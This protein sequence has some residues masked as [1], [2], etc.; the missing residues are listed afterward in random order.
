VKQLVDD[1]IA[2]EFAAP[3]LEFCWQ[4]D[5]PSDPEK[6]AQIATDYVKAGIK[7]VNEVRAELGLGPVAGGEMPLVMTAQGPVPLGAQPAAAAREPLARFNPNHYGSGPQGG[8]FAPA[9]E[10]G[11][12]G[13][14]A[15]TTGRNAQIAQDESEEEKAA[16]NLPFVGKAEAVAA[17]RNPAAAASE[18]QRIL[19]QNPA[20]YANARAAFLQSALPVPTAT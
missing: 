1:I 9:G 4:D 20:D 19:Q 17:A 5:P 14:A 10:D 8:Q 15:G 11:A 6:A 7:S 13:A 16:R 12:T 3:D 18:L 2:D